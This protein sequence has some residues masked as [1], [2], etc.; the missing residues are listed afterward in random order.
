MVVSRRLL[1][2]VAALAALVAAGA[3]LATHDQRGARFE[4]LGHVQP[5]TGYSA[6]VVLHRRHAF[7][8]SHKGGAS[9][10]AA[11]VGVYSL[12]DPRRPR[13]IATFGR[14]PGTWTEK[15]IV[16]RVSTPAFTGDLAVTSVQSCRERAFR[17]FA[18]YDVT[19]PG[20]PRE[21]ARVRTEPRGSHELWLQRVGRRAYVYTAIVASEILSSTDGKPGEPD[22]RIYD[23]TRPRRPVLR[24]GWGAWR[25][26][27]LV[28]FHDPNRRLEGNFV[29]SV[30]GDG[31]R[32]YL[33]YWDLGT[34]VLDVRD[35]ARPRYVGRTRATENAHSAWLGPRGLLIETH[36]A[37]GG[38]AT[39]HRRAATGDPVQLSTF[40]LPDSVIRR[41]HGVRGLAPVSGLDLTDSVHDAKLQGQTALFS[42]YAQGVVAADVSDPSR[43]R[44]L[45]RFLPRPDEDPERLLCP[46]SRC[47]AV[48]GVD[49]EGD[50]VVA[51]DMVS[52]LWILQLRRD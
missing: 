30:V 2:A 23:V 14:I 29:H 47:T 19:R 7:L 11:G 52:G 12:R 38:V 8:S 35:P 15:T 51:S 4:V 24:G 44:F 18:L 10:P 22:F 25:A 50:L 46:R 43:P 13:R 5:A 31:A 39:L 41:G 1:A 34:V 33:S 32:A 28:P 17:G 40:E 20:R 45:A 26:L 48:W 6:D 37:S 9:C 3:A 36:E 16:Q 21:L 49:V 27:G 42:W